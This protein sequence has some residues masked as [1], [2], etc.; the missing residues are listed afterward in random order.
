MKIRFF[1]YSGSKYRF[2]DIINEQ[3]SLLPKSDI[4]VEPFVGSGSIL[5]NLEKE[6]DRY[7]INDKDRNIIRI[8]ESFKDISYDEYTDIKREVE[9]E[10]GEFIKIGGRS[11]KINQ[12]KES[13]YLFREYFNKN[14][15]NK[16][17]LLEGI[18]LHILAN[19]CINSFLRFGPNGMN[20]GF[21]DG[22]YELNETT[23][24]YISKIIKKSEIYN[25]DFLDLEVPKNST[26]FLDPPY[27]LRPSSYDT[28]T[29]NDLK[30]ILNKASNFNFCY[31]DLLSNENKHLDRREIRK[32]R[33]TSPGIN[34]EKEIPEYVFTHVKD[35]IGK[36]WIP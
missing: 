24:N 20:Q 9:K 11:D 6:Y 19:K 30:I 33:N 21:G 34:S 22:T 35:N 4:F 28:I 1:R 27:Y 17:T 36:K 13:Y 32:M 5:F 18:Y 2:T 15:R 14:H 10:F 29:A 3:L 16:N 12:A 31:T 25:T 26:L 7:V 8:Y 23:F